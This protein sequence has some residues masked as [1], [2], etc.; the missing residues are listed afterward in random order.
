MSF[1]S[2]FVKNY[3]EN[4]ENKVVNDFRDKNISDFFWKTDYGEINPFSKTKIP[5]G[6]V[7]KLFFE[8]LFSL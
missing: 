6:W 7:N 5:V 4:W 1:W 8:A 2:Y 3:P